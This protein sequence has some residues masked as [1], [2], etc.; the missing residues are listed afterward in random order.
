MLA[1]S[2]ASVWCVCVLVNGSELA[3]F[4]DSRKQAQG[5]LVMN[6]GKLPDMIVLAGALDFSLNRQI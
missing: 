3:L 6:A 5:P 2:S 4:L 1:D